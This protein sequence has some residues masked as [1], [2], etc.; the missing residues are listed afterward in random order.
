MVS[1]EFGWRREDLLDLS[2]EPDDQRYPLVCCDEKLYH[3]V[4]DTRQA[5]PGRPGQPRRDDDE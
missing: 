3:R 4:S 2:A 5:L 1:A